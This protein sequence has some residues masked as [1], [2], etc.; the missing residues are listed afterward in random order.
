M[1]SLFNTNLEDESVKMAL[2]NLKFQIAEKGHVTHQ[3][4]GP[5]ILYPTTDFSV[6]SIRSGITII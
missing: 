5:S 2:L 6:I 4:R 3:L 1:I